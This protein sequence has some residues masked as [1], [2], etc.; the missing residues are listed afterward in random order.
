MNY[1]AFVIKNKGALHT[2]RVHSPKQQKL[3]L[4]FSDSQVLVPCTV[5]PG[6]VTGYLWVTNN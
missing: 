3:T 5:H 6:K 2:V 1:G 4:N